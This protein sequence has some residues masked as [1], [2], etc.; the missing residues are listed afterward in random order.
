MDLLT[1]INVTPS[2]AALLALLLTPACTL[3]TKV[4][5]NPDETGEDSSSGTDGA[6]TT[7]S[8]SATEGPADTEDQTEPDDPSATSAPPDPTDG[9]PTEGEPC[10]VIE[11]QLV[12]DE[13]G[14]GGFSLEQLLADK[15]G[16]R[17][18][19]LQFASE[20]LALS[21]QWKGK[22]LPV[23]VELTYTGGQ[24]VWIDSEVN[25]EY[26]DEDEGLGPHEE[27][28][29]SLEAEVELDFV[30][31][32]G[33]FAEHRTATLRASTVERASLQVDLTP[34]LTGSFDHTSLYSDPEW[35]STAVSVAGT[36]DGD[37]AGG[38]LNNEVE[39]DG[40]TVGFGSIARWGDE[41]E[42]AFP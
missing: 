27:C 2:R 1:R 14:P 28:N 36:W 7:S 42:P 39:L 3:D 19:T 21:D 8:A 24:V 9:V 40:G 37:K 26:D 12:L 34:D 11:T 38:D 30:T 6:G 5:G 23:T 18:S 20:P 32:A 4:G 10:I 15:L 33:E 35:T 17:A 25:P 13:V 41:I 22:A 29:D 31:E 16:P